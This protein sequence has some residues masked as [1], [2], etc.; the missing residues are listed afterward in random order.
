MSLY[1]VTLNI[2]NKL[3]LVVGGGVVALRK[4][5]SLLVGGAEIRVISPTL[6]P[7]F[8]G[9]VENQAIEW[10]GRGFA[11]GDLKGVFLVFAATNDHGIQELVS[12][13]AEKYPVLLN[14]VDDPQKSHFHV[15]AHFRRGKLLV[16]VSTGGSSPALAKKLRQQLETELAPGYEMVVELLGI[17]RDKVVG[18][19]ANSTANGEL[20]RRLLDQ[21]IV[22]LT[23]E[24]NWFGL[25]MLLLRE[26][27]PSI[28]AVA[29][30]KN[31]LEQYDQ[32]DL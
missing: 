19:G 6:H 13:E 32:P 30:M 12:R 16:T 4:T 31:F 8:E 1:P 27:P 9:L 3:C 25:Q 7:A 11:E 10:F 23:L 15:P 14:S 24:A 26:L 20:F 28:D 2:S 21:G 22:E 18:S 29:L 17:I 5:R